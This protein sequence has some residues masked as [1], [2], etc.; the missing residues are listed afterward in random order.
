MRPRVWPGVKGIVSSNKE[1]WYRDQ[2]FSHSGRSVL[3]E[4]GL[5]ETDTRE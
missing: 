2:D 3:L 1:W 5:M 4:V